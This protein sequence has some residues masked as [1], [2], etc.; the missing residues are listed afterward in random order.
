L[1][2]TIKQDQNYSEKIKKSLFIGDLKYITEIDSAKNILQTI[3]KNYP[4]ADHYC[5]AFII[6]DYGEIRFS[7][8]NKEPSGSAGKPILNMLFRH[9]LTNNILVVTRFFGGVKLGMKGLIEAYS[10]VAEKT[11]LLG[12]KE[13]VEKFFFYS[14]SM[15]YSF[16]DPF[17]HSLNKFDITIQSVDYN[18]IVEVTIR[19]KESNFEYLKEHLDCLV[20]NNKI[21]IL[22]FN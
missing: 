18:E 11:I 3:I 10:T 7:S 15:A 8:D 14:C 9:E 12:E 20:V 17:L 4:Q 5:H 13:N 2:Y 16:Y 6:G 21:K 1:K 22:S 19:V